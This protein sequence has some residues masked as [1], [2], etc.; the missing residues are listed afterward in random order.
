M[1]NAIVSQ[2]CNMQV[3][4][5]HNQDRSAA[6]APWPE[7]SDKWGVTAVGKRHQFWELEG[8]ANQ[9]REWG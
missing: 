7:V 2:Y 6:P 3:R 1:C 4:S 5:E 8:W 9:V